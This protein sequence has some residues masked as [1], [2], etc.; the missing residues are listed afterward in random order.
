MFYRYPKKLPPGQTAGEFLLLYSAA[1]FITEY[2]RSPDDGFILGLT[3]GQFW[4]LPLAFLGLFLIFRTRL[5]SK[6]VA[7]SS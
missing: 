4:T 1:R 5:F 2:F 6:D 7:R 3:A